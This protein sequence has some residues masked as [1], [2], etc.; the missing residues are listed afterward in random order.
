MYKKQIML[1]SRGFSNPKAWPD[2]ALTVYPWDSEVDEFLLELSRKAQ[3]R[4]SVLFDLVAKLC[5]MNGGK[6]DDFVA[7]ET[8]IVLLMARA[9]SQNDTITYTSSCPFCGTQDKEVIGVPDELERVSEK[10]A[11]YPGFDVITLPVCKDV[12]AVRPLLIR[13]ERIILER[14]TEERAKV[15]DT[16]LRNILRVVTVN[17]TTADSL[18]ELN[19]WLMALPPV[20]SR[21]FE[22]KSR[23]LSPHLNNVIPH[24]C[25]NEA[26]KRPFK[27]TLTFDQ[28]FFR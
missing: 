18:G 15:P 16:N 24:V 14:P 27:H 22:E 20:D 11:D 5:D 12:V 2:G 26:C 28:D 8:N 13:D 19:M 23:E 17:D 3:S 9:I 21:F 25:G 6:I 10:A 4:Q 7:D 1:P